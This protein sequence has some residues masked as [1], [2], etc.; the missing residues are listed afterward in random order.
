MNQSSA[1][2]FLVIRYVMASP[3]AQPRNETLLWEEKG[4]AKIISAGTWDAKRPFKSFIL[5][6]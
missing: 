2:I 5:I 3:A 4:N 1:V 6:T